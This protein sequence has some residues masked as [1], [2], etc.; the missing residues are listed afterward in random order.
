MK[1]LVVY[2]I[3]CLVISS[4]GTDIIYAEVKD[5]PKEGWHKDSIYSFTTDSL[6]DMPKYLK[7]GFD[8][9]NTVDYKY[10][11]IYLF[12]EI[13]IPG[14]KP[15]K[16]TLDHL[17]MSP[18]GFWLENVEGST[19]KESTK[20]YKY[21]IQNPPKGKYTLTVQQGMRDSILTNIVSVGARIEKLEK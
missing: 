14:Q 16:D 1:K 4:C 19:I 8:L 20:Y 18:D 10:R 21:A 7:I 17:L 11:N 13:S 9:R 3:T 2:L 6:V 12:V 15:I 5:L